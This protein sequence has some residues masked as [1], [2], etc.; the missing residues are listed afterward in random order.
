MKGYIDMNKL[1]LPLVL[2]F[3]SLTCFGQPTSEQI[4]EWRKAAEQG[5]A[6]AQFNLGV[7]YED[8]NGIPEDDAEA[9]KW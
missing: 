8:G 5:N 6:K 3:V 4:K 9:I 7:L 2:L 1:L